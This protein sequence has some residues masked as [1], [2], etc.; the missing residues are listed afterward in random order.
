MKVNTL[1]I[2]R[3]ISII[4]Y[5]YFCYL[6]LVVPKIEPQWEGYPDVNDCR[7]QSEADLVSLDFY[8]P[9]PRMWFFPRPFTVPLFFKIVDSDPYKMAML[10][11]FVYCICVISLLVTLL[12]YIDQ[13]KLKIITLYTLLFFFTWWNI[14]GWS[15]LPLS[16]SLSI[17]LMLLWF[18][19]ILFYYKEQGSLSFITLI[20]VSFFFRLQEIPGLT[21][22]FRFL[23]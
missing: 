3:S 14:M 8:A 22:Y 17:S 12:N 11:K 2:F 19:S 9:K 18:S 10:Q 13:K 23:Y 20:I 4:G 7:V 16:E 6:I 15:N 5:M 21:L 1:N